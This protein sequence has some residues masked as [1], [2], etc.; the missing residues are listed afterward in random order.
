LELLLRVTDH[1]NT[2]YLGSMRLTSR[3]IM[4]SHEGIFIDQFFVRKQFM[5]S[6]FSLQALIDIAKSRL[7]RYMRHVHISLE[8]RQ[9]LS[10]AEYFISREAY[11][12]HQAEDMVF[13]RTSMHEAM[14][15]DAFRSLPVLESVVMRG[16]NST[17]RTRD[18]IGHQWNSYGVPTANETLGGQVYG[19][20]PP[21]KVVFPCVLYALGRAAVR[22][23]SIEI[24]VR[25]HQGLF[26]AEFATCS[27]T[28]PLVDPVVRNLEK[29]HVH[30]RRND[31]DHVVWGR[32]DAEADALSHFPLFRRFLCRASALRDLRI[33][34][35]SGIPY[36]DATVLEW[37]GRPV[38]PSSSVNEQVGEEPQTAGDGVVAVESSAAGTLFTEPRTVSL[39][40]LTSLSLGFMQILPGDLLR[41]VGKLAP[42]LQNLELW[43]VTLYAS[44][45]S[46]LQSWWVWPRL[47][48]EMKE[49]PDL[50]LR[51]IKLGMLRQ[52]CP[53]E[54]TPPTRV[55]F[56]DNGDT[57]EY[58]GLDW[59]HFAEEAAEAIRRNTVRPLPRGTFQ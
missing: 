9:S 19:Y 34:F 40:H 4:E 13:W 42:T 14:L 44:A 25:P 5:M 6:R 3:F 48:L 16:F 37:L 1:L 22:P 45:H 18:G 43:R 52:T 49:I 50:E 58:T 41:L 54:P 8:K 53:L 17:K 20:S 26:D 56:E 47:L 38:D 10:S 57:V 33:N 55:L 7:G 35:N 24:W 51:H 12:K 30:L 11:V 36:E 21:N 32:M 31:G 28:E 23:K 59:R 27:F 39:P 29:L 2:V 15:V 46:D